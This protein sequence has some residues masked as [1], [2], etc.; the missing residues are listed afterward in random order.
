MAYRLS[1]FICSVLVITGLSVPVFG[2]TDWPT[3]GHDAASTRHSPLKQIDTNNVSKMVTGEY[4]WRVPLGIVPELEAKGIHNTGTMNIGGSATTSGL[5]FIGAT[6]DRHF[7]AFDAKNGK[8][9]WDVEL[10]T[11]AYASPAIYQGKNG[12]EY[13]VIVADGGGY[14]DKLGGDSVIAF[15][16]P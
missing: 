1:M 12:K 2:Q 16:L 11:G 8:V 5:V 6:N 4:A 15:T 3:Y 9:L 14:Y 10:E 13:V 7:R